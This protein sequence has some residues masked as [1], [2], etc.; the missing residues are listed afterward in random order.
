MAML[1]YDRMLVVV[2][3]GM[4]RTGHFRFVT[5]SPDPAPPKLA[6]R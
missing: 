2:E 3:A 6:D 4:E 5:A 1:N